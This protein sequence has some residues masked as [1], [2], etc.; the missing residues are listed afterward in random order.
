MA[1]EECF[2][3]KTVVDTCEPNYNPL[4]NSTTASAASITG[5][6]NSRII[7]SSF[8]RCKQILCKVQY[9]LLYTRLPLRKLRVIPYSPDGGIRLLTEN[10]M[11][12]TGRVPSRRLCYE[13]DLWKRRRRRCA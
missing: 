13:I 4:K 10:V 7:S 6:K 11:M 9:F 5:S 2:C 3:C 1:S 8:S 12:A